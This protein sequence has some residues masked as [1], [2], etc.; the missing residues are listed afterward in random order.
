MGWN[1]AFKSRPK[2]FEI[3]SYSL[4]SRNIK[5]KK[6]FKTS[7][8]L[9]A[10]KWHYADGWPSK[11]PNENN[12]LSSFNTK[13]VFCIIYIFI[14]F[15]LKLTRT[16]AQVSTSKQNEKPTFQNRAMPT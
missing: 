14:F 11:K 6:D 9:V 10:N 7:R 13:H 4:I 16:E 5:Q 8:V 1:R 2:S 12:L 15:C 3:I